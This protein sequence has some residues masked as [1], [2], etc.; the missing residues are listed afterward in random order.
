[1]LPEARLEQ[2]DAGLVP[3]GEGW[4]VLN[5]KDAAWLSHERFGSA[6]TW[7]GEPQFDQLG[8]NVGVLEPGQPACMYHG[9]D[10]Q[11]DFLVLFGECLLLVEGQERRLRAWDFVH[12]PAWTEHVFIG[13]GDGPC[14][15]V[16]VGAGGADAIVYPV[17]DLALRHGAGVEQEARD[18]QRAYA[19]FPRPARTRY[20]GQLDRPS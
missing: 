11:E 10:A 12:C 6:C 8:I 14:A 5:T 4:F 9:E 13:A 2:T 17:N 7:E 3:H 16:A 18:P 1:M 20:S 15:I 19:R